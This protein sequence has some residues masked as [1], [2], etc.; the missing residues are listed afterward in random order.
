MQVIKDKTVLIIPDI[1]QCTR[2]AN[3]ALENNEYDHVVFLG[4]YFDCFESPGINGRVSIEDMCEWLNDKYESLGDKATWL[5]GNHDVSYLST[6]QPRSYKVLKHTENYLCSGW[7]HSK[8]SKINKRLNPNFLYNL[9]LCVQIDDFICSH[10]GFHESHFFP[11]KSAIESIIE[12]SNRWQNDRRTFMFSHNHWIGNVG[13]CRNGYSKVGSPIWLDWN[14]E[15]KPIPD[16]LQI[17]GH[18]EDYRTRTQQG[19]ICIDC[20]CSV[21]AI[22]K[23]NDCQFVTI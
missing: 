5:L 13:V 15:F 18:T 8:A 11:M 16:I 23:N 7:S 20:G 10:A 1:H 14:Y 21:Y 19:N 2:F 3:H 4:D 12:L 17:V 9:E 22:V 6:F